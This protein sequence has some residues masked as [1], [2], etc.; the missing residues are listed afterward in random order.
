MLGRCCPLPCRAH[1]QQ[2]SASVHTRTWTNE[3]PVFRS[4]TREQCGRDLGGGGGGGGGA[5]GRE[6]SGENLNEVTH[7]HMLRQQSARDL[8]K[9]V[10]FSFCFFFFFLLHYSTHSTSMTQSWETDYKQASF[11]SHTKDLVCQRV[12]W[13]HWTFPWRINC[14]T[15]I[16]ERLWDKFHFQSQNICM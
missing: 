2:G 5:G 1:T 13:S 8:G 7:R 10:H 14:I 4:F 6:E 3:Q 15:V 11:C 12:E 9:I 16:W